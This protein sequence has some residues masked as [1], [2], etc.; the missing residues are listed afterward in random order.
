VKRDCH[1]LLHTNTLSLP[2]PFH[3]PGRVYPSAFARVYE[4]PVVKGE[5]VK[6]HTGIPT[7][8]SPEH[9]RL[10]FTIEVQTSTLRR[11]AGIGWHRVKISPTACRLA[12]GEGIVDNS[13]GGIQW[14]AWAA[15]FAT[16]LAVVVALWKED[17]VKHWRRPRLKA[18]VSLQPPDCHKIPINTVNRATGEV[19]ESRDAYFFRIWIENTGGVRAEN[20]QVFAAG[21]RRKKAGGGFEKVGSFLPMNLKWAHTG[22]VF[23]SGLS[24]KMGR[25]C[26]LGYIAAPKARGQ[27]SK[28]DPEDIKLILD[29]EVVPNTRS[30]ECGPGEY[31]LRLR[32]AAS[33]SPPLEATCRLTLPGKWYDDESEML[34][35]GIGIDLTT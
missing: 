21:L 19:I 6:R 17:I 30:N 29:T 31:E 32:I 8:V 2:F 10:E 12:A 22:E 5:K 4:T 7:A 16:F 33:N 28:A 3:L 35:Q 23:A 1:N 34:S 24:P 15:A 9:S 18:G 13:S 20:V 25:H 14:A 26:D 11:I 27:G